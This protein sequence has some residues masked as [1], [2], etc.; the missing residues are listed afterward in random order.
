MRSTQVIPLVGGETIE[1]PVVALSRTLSIALLMVND[2]SYER[3]DMLTD[4]LIR[5]AEEIWPRP[6]AVVGIPE[7][8][9]WL[10]H[11]VARGLGLPRA[12][13]LR[14]SPKRWEQY[15]VARLRSVTKEAEQHLYM[16]EAWVG[17]LRGK[18]VL[19]VED[20][21]STGSTVVAAL[22]LLE[23]VAEVVGILVVFVEG[24]AWASRL[25]PRAALVRSLGRLS[26]L[27]DDGERHS[28]DGPDLR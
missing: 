15:R 4:L 19:L 8:G 10:A 22:E 16:P 6:E 23:W 3:V 13:I 24:L 2:E 14:K 12:Y 21:I 26:I 5:Q 25:G 9:I 11:S 17:E 20:V 27:W 28:T 7:Q 18:R 1:L